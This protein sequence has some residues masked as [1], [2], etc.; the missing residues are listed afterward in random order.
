LRDGNA[1]LAR[2]KA[3]Q[4]VPKRGLKGRKTVANTIH[5]I[6]LDAAELAV[7]RQVVALLRHP[8]ASLGELTRQAI[9]YLQ[10]V[11]ARRA[12]PFPAP[13]RGN[14]IPMLTKDIPY[15]TSHKY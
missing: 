15:S 12:L 4:G 3:R 1:A 6:G 5:M 14:Q 8:D 11:A 9:H 7:L 2:V 13:E 10:D